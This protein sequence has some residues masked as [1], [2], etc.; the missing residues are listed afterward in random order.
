MPRA[1][2]GGVVRRAEVARAAVATSPRTATYSRCPPHPTSLGATW[3]ALLTPPPLATR[4]H[5]LLTSASLGATC[6]VLFETVY[7]ETTT[8]PG[9]SAK[10]HSLSTSLG[11]TWHAL[12]IPS[13]GDTWHALL[14][15]LPLATRGMPSSSLPLATRGMPSSRHFPWW[16]AHRR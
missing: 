7:E 14:T 9:V 13:F 11:D 2:K 16:L 5:A 4:G 10:A 6:Q 8:F 12:L 15:P 1:T 3:H